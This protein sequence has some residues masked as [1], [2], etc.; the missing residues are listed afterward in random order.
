MATGSLSN[1]GQRLRRVD[2]AGWIAWR[3]QEDHTRPWADGCVEGLKIQVVPFLLN[4]GHWHRHSSGQTDSCL[5]AGK[6]GIGIDHLI[7][8]LEDGHHG[9]E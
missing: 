1:V 2:P 4:Q 7:T 5:I 9:Q 8:R 3:I 6:T